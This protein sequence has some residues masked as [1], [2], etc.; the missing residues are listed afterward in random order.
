MGRLGRVDAVPLLSLPLRRSQHRRQNTVEGGD[1]AA[2]HSTTVSAPIP[3]APGAF[4]LRLA[5][6]VHVRVRYPT[7]WTAVDL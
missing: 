6:R 4:G 7:I 5:F 1:N 3:V 2:T